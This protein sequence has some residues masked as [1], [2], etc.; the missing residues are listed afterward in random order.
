MSLPAPSTCS[1]LS[2]HNVISKPHVPRVQT[3][4]LNGVPDCTSFLACRSPD[5]F[6]QSLLLIGVIFTTLAALSPSA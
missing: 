6:L 5:G 3:A 2:C 1:A 4:W